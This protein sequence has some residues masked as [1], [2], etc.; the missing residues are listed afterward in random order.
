MKLFWRVYLWLFAAAMVTFLLAGLQ[1][2]RTI[3]RVYQEQVAAE[4][5]AQADWMAGEL[6]MNARLP[7]YD[8]VDARCKEIGR[9]AHVRV[10]V[11]LPDGRVVGDSDVEPETMENHANRPEIQEALAGRTGK[12]ERFSDTLRRMLSY[13][14]VPVQRDGKVV[15]VVR[16]SMPLA[17]IDR[18]LA[19]LYDPGTEGSDN[20]TKNRQ[21]KGGSEASQPGVVRWLGDIRQYFPSTVV[22]VMQ[23]DALERLH[24][25]HRAI[26]RQLEKLAGRVRRGKR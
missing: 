19:S 21:R 2:D 22:R 23:K 7:A 14:A 17:S 13:L 4:L 15:A 6:N 1:A 5:Q 12:S 18:A 9:V 8:R 10:T 20:L 25:L 26:G 16:T 11:I 24:T 3:R